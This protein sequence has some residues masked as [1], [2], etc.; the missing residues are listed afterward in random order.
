MAD[1]IIVRCSYCG[2][3]IG[4]VTF[5]SGEQQVGCPHCKGVTKVIIGKDGSV[6]MRQ[7]KHP[8]RA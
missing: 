5:V 6:E 2:K 4:K 3:E 7:H 1:T 8:S